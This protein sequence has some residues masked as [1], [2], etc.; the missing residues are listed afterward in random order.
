MIKKVIGIFILLGVI[1]LISCQSGKP[2]K[3]LS[4]EGMMYA[5]IYD[6]DNMPVSGVAVFINGRKIVDSDIQGRFIL[7]S[8]KKGEYSVRLTKRGYETLEENFQFDPLQVL[9]IKMINTAQL[10]DLAEIALDNADFATA[11][12]YILR[13][14]LL[15]PTRPDIL[16]LKSIV[17][18][19]QARNEEAIDSLENL[20]MTGNDNPSISRLLEMVR[21]I[22]SSEE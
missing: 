9:Y 13:A 16:Y 15:E 18:Y 22:E 10:V 19:L 8:M 5:M 7:T 4:D 12:K 17:F 6:Y 20:I 14:L 2:I 21:Q 11:E 3:M 1:L